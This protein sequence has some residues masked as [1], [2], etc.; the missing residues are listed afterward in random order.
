MEEGA[1][2][3]CEGIRNLVRSMFTSRSGD[4]L[5]S[6]GWTWGEVPAGSFTI[7]SIRS[8]KNM[9]DEYATLRIKIYAGAGDAFYFRF[10]EYGT[11]KGLPARPTFY[12]TWKKMKT[13][14]ATKI[15]RRVK[16]AVREAWR[17][18]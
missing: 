15:R 1:E 16:A 8:G 10:H 2:E 14:F 17:N 4:M 3:I 5:K 11:H 7:A 9:G 6:I 18:G 13:E 12:P